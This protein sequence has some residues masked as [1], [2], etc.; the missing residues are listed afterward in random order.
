[1]LSA[2]GIILQFLLPMPRARVGSDGGSIEGGFHPFPDLS[3]K[4]FVL[5][6]W[7]DISAFTYCFAE[8]YN[9][10]VVSRTKFLVEKADYVLPAL[11]EFTPVDV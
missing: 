3:V 6:T 8:P 5:S 10:G 7:L 11:R 2:S 1:M 4:V 9:D